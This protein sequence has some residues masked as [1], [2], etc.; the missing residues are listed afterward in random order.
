M[1]TKTKNTYDASAIQ[2]FEGVYAIRKRP[3]MYINYT[4]EDGNSHL[5]RE[6]IDNSV[7]E[8]LVGYCDKIDVELDIDQGVYTIVDNGRG[9][10]VTKNPDKY[11]KGSTIPKKDNVLH[12]IVTKTHSGGKFDNNAYQVSGGLNGVGTTCINA[13][14]DYMQIISMRDGFIYEQEYAA[15]EPQTEL[16]VTGTTK[17]TGTTFVFRPDVEIMKTT[18]INYD[19]T[20]NDIKLRA[21]LNPGLKINVTVIKDGKKEVFKYD[22]TNGI[23]DL[24]QERVKENMLSQIIHF[25][26]KNVTT[27]V[28]DIS[29]AFTYEKGFD[30]VTSEMIESFANG[31]HTT[32]GGTH[33]TAFKKAITDN[34]SKFMKES[35]LIPSIKGKPM[36]IKGDDYRE[37]I[38][39][40]IS[41]KLTDPEYIGQGKRKLGNT[42]IQGEIMSLMNNEF[43]DWLVSNPELSK[44][45]V[46]KV[47]AA[48]KGRQAAKRAKEAVQNTEKSDFLSFSDF[49]K[50]KDCDPDTP[51]EEAELY[52]CEGDSASGT[53]K[54][55][56]NPKTQ[57]I[58]PL[59][60]KILNTFNKAT[61]SFI[62]PK[63][64]AELTNLV[65][66]MKAGI[67]DNFNLSKFRYKGGVFL[68][69][70]ADK[71]GSHIQALL[72]SFFEEFLPEVIEAGLLKITC[73]P[74]YAITEKGQRTYFVTDSDYQAFII[75]RAII[76][77]DKKYKVNGGKKVI[78]KVFNALFNYESKIKSIASKYGNQELVEYTALLQIMDEDN[79][80]ANLQETDE[81]V[82]DELDGDYVLTGFYKNQFQFIV[83][84]EEFFEDLA[85]I[86]EFIYAMVD[87]GG[88]ALIT[89]KE[90]DED[91]LLPSIISDI[92]RK[93]TPSTRQRFKG[94]GEND[95]EELED[96]IMDKE[97]RIVYTV[98]FDNL[99]TA[100][101]MVNTLFNP[102][103]PDARKEF[104]ADNQHL[105][106]T[107]MLDI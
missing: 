53:L 70:D 85:V 19:I 68:A 101:E 36:E 105:I 65:R 12:T 92:I 102:K 7:D 21:I 89:E 90:S 10:P 103:I 23:A 86:Q 8:S 33:V 78:K 43:Y 82:I 61:G 69:T 18:D 93:V 20:M 25:N 94:L 14:S 95:Q 91:V 49:G 44:L 72:L 56:R 9:I 55:A 60:G 67:G 45:I 51:D 63:G 58:F 96:T 31:V 34:I 42:D 5:I 77:F 87:D 73:P 13:L 104:I 59:R 41:V 76:E 50:L 80:L 79:L 38:S 35:K 88:E 98:N 2:D 84:N 39:A 48:A 27:N 46:K 6:G 4:G 32:E 71:D 107:S 97:K 17:K 29:I 75:D 99:E 54:K 64:N 24:L 11:K 83:M 106:D 26:A 30:D 47:I 37:G 22:Y 81:I 28:V 52:I 1:T 66:L 3:T 62:G 16:T 40:V 15:G 57:A 74:L 100:K